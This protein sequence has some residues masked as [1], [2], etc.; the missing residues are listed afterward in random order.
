MKL[1]WLHVYACFL[2]LLGVKSYG[3]Y[4]LCLAYSCRCN[5]EVVQ[6]PSICVCVFSLFR[7]YNESPSTNRTVQDLSWTQ[8]ESNGL[9]VSV[10]GEANDIQTTKTNNKGDYYM[11]FALHVHV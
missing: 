10:S 7:L 11:Y 8:T 4:V 5:M 9:Q 1:C 3:G 6:R 2:I